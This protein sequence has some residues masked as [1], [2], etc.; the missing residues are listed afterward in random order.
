[1][2]KQYNSEEVEQLAQRYW[3]ENLSFKCI[4]DPTKEKYYCLSMFLYPSGDLHMG[5]VRNYTIGDV[6]SRHKKMLG[7][8]VLQPT[9]WDAFGLPAENAAIK[10]NVP[11]AKWTYQNIANMK[12][13]LKQ[14]GFG[15]DWDREI[16]TCNPKYYRWEQWLFLQ[17][18]KKGLVYKK[19]AAVNWDP[20]D[21]TV[22]ANE[23]VVNGRGWRSG[24]LVEKRQISQWFVK[25]TAYAEELLAGLDTLTGWPEQVKTMQRNWIGRSEGANIHFKLPNSNEHIEVY[26]TRPD[27]IMGVTY[28]AIAAEHPLAII[29][30]KT[31]IQI[32]DFLEKCKNTKVSEVE[33]ATGEKLGINTGLK[34]INPLSGKLIPVWVTNYVLADYGS[35]ALMAVP[36]HDE[37]D[38]EFAKKYNIE[39]NQVIAPSE[40]IKVDLNKAAFTG[41]GT[42]INSEQ[43]NDL[44][45]AAACS[46]I[47]QDL[48]AKNAGQKQINFRLRDWGVSRQRYWGTPIPI[49]YCEHCG[50][51]PV[52]EQDLPVVL[53]EN[54]EFSG[55]NSPL[56]DMPGFYKTSCPKCGKEAKRETDTFDTFF[57]SSWYYARFACPDQHAGMF[58]KRVHYWTPV[59]Q[60]IGGIEHAVLH[61]LYARF[62][63]KAMRDLEL[64]NT[65]E[66]FTNLLTQGMVLKDGSK[67]S[68][69]LGNTVSPTKLVEQYGADTVRLFIMFTSHPEQSLEWSDAGVEGAHRFL[70]RLWA[71]DYQHIEDGITT[72]VTSGQL[73]E[74]QKELR[75]KLHSTLQKV[76]DDMN[77]RYTFNTAIAA[78]MELLNHLNNHPIQDGND[79][80]IRQ[81]ILDS[82]ILMLSPIIPHITHSLWYALGHKNAVINETWP[83]PEQAAL[84]CDT[85]NIT[86]QVNGKLRANIIVDPA[87]SKAV[88]E[89]TALNHPNVQRYLAGSSVKKIIIVPN[90][91]INI[92]IGE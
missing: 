9:G 76:S 5:H 43:Y 51:V 70:K 86:V 84:A 56:K 29:A 62:F 1:M 61:L 28:M 64:V 52:A 89:E 53:P 57:E 39:I 42:L 38:W 85:I 78:I 55:H 27:T 75:R 90:K 4:E 82:V 16:A 41:T 13:Q 18:Y 83:T 33:L 45:S 40:D 88:L 15:Y 81:E 17:L 91:L 48:V 37:R 12:A 54:I 80:A 63:H 22:L 73:T 32:R 8:N 59:D 20:V 69:S 46:A 3:E 10:N 44:D 6:I 87:A 71:N 50:T 34:V 66:P 49:I 14:L 92:V 65:D 77:R 58:D 35:G 72:S 30:A 68:K 7:K 31:N 24:A 11:P 67:M 25:I 36:A 21:Q 74:Q 23:Q 47:I 26:T 60:Y 2:D 19:N 79:R